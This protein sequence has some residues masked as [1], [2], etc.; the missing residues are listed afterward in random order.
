[1]AL[2]F[3]FTQ[4]KRNQFIVHCFIRIIQLRVFSSKSFKTSP[5]R[6]YPAHLNAFV[7]NEPRYTCNGVRGSTWVCLKYLD[8]SYSISRYTAIDFL[9]LLFLSLPA[10]TCFCCEVIPGVF[11]FLAHRLADRNVVELKV[12][13]TV[14]SNYVIVF[15]SSYKVQ[16]P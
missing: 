16:G 1:M 3:V 13:L 9:R 8:E 6:P 4:Q 10:F 12:T 5:P 15:V 2:L 14:E 7:V 11:L